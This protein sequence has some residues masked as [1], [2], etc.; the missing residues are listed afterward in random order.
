MDSKKKYEAKRVVKPVSLLNIEDADIL[1]SDEDGLYTGLDMS[2][3]M[4][5]YNDVDVE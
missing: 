2:K 5:V 1:Q 3:D 4:D